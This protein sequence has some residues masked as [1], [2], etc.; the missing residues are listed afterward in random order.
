M[1]PPITLESKIVLD[2]IVQAFVREVSSKNVNLTLN[3]KCRD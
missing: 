3:Q 1:A 2:G